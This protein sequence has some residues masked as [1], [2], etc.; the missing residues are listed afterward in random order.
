MKRYKI[1]FK[2]GSSIEVYK[3]ESSKCFKAGSS[4]FHED[5]LAGL[6]TT[7]TEI[8][9]ARREYWIYWDVAVSEPYPIA[10]IKKPEDGTWQTMFKVV[11]L[12][13]GEIIVN[14]EKLE[15]ALKKYSGW[16]ITGLLEKI[17][18]ELGLE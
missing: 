9:P 16:Y 15:S 5:D 6:K 11:E 2:N 14:K 1:N 7:I 18:K 12:K 17:Y 4:I 3:D 8:D 10:S 13:E